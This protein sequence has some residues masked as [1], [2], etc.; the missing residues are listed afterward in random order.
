ML[1]NMKAAATYLGKNRETIRLWKKSGR[2][3]NKAAWTEDE[4]KAAAAAAKA[5][6]QAESGQETPDQAKSEADQAKAKP[7]N[8][9]EPVGPGGAAPAPPA[10]P[11]KPDQ[12][13][14]GGVPVPNFPKPGE[15]GTPRPSKKDKTK[16]K[17]DT[18]A[19]REDVFSGW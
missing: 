5:S 8:R 19:P 16:A 6:D 12:A 18:T 15:H 14:S 13:K 2:L 3:P 17:A 11:A 9:G 7:E 4:L 10:P 1:Y